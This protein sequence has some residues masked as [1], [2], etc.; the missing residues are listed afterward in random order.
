MN[1]NQCTDA[2]DRVARFAAELEVSGFRQDAIIDALLSVG[3]NA[4]GKMSPRSLVFLLET[5][6][7]PNAKALAAEEERDKTGSTAH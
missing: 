2:A 4:A 5:M 6:A 7:L 3:L 1:D